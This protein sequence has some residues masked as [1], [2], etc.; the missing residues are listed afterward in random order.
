M[1]GPLTCAFPET[2]KRSD[3]CSSL[4]EAPS[5]SSIGFFLQRG[6]EGQNFTTIERERGGGL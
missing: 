4:T 1:V 5:F 6:T 3:K 2:L